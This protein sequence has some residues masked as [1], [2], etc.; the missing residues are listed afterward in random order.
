MDL[1]ATSTRGQPFPNEPRNFRNRIAV[2][3]FAGLS[4]PIKCPAMPCFTPGQR[5]VRG[6]ISFALAA[7]VNGCAG[8]EPPDKISRPDVVEIQPVPI[9]GARMPSGPIQ[10]T[11]RLPAGKGP[12]P[13]V[14]VL[15]GCSGLGDRTL[16]WAGRLN[17]W[18]YAAL[19]PDSWTPR[20]IR[21]VC[22]SPAWTVTPG[23]RM[24]DVA[25]AVAWMR[26]QPAIDPNA[27]AVLGT[28]HGGW[29]AATAVDRRYADLR[30]SAAID[31]HGTCT[32]P[33]EYG[34][35]PLLALLGEADDW[36][37]P[38]AVC[39][40]YAA[41]LPHGAAVEVHTYPGANHSFDYPGTEPLIRAGHLEKY[42]K[43]AAEDSYARVRAFLERTIGAGAR[44]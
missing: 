4:K 34:G 2:A 31:Y 37:N 15:H 6:W 12:F 27:I 41:R 40:G 23:D 35:V 44:H 22:D 8:M 28:G 20:G 32:G 29:T 30:L 14:I 9:S 19:L 1:N 42:D 33:G 16:L 36:G 3:C 39:L 13:A 5:A 43:T 18:G 10:A 11:F 38:A 25:S 17:S 24:G 7:I 21:S 26:T